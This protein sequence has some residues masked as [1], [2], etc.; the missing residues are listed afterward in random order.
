[1]LSRPAET[2]RRRGRRRRGGWRPPSSLRTSG[3]RS[4][5]CALHPSRGPGSLP[6]GGFRGGPAAIERTVVLREGRRRGSRS[7]RGPRGRGDAVPGGF[8]AGGAR[9]GAPPGGDGTRRMAGAAPAFPP[10]PS[11]GGRHRDGRGHGDPA[12]VEEAVPEGTESLDGA[13]ADRVRQYL[14]DRRSGAAAAREQLLAGRPAGRGG[15]RPF[16]PRGSTS[17]SSPRRAPAEIPPG[18]RSSGRRC[19]RSRF[20]EGV[21]SLF[22]VT[23]RERPGADA[24]QRRG[25]I[26]E[27]ISAPRREGGV[28][29]AGAGDR[30]GQGKGPHGS[31]AATDRGKTMTRTVA[32]H[33]GGGGGAAAFAGRRSPRD[34]RRR[35][36]GE[37]GADHLFRGAPSRCR[38]GWGSPWATRTRS[39]ANSAIPARCSAGRALVDSVLV[40]QGTGEAGP[41]DRG[42]GRSTGRR[43]RP[44]GDAMSEA[45]SPTFSEEGISRPRTA[46]LRWQMERGAIAG[47]GSSRRSR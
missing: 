32:T 20:R 43:I 24:G 41:A 47:R 34:R 18:V 16:R 27:A 7:P 5:R 28:P 15:R 9:E 36:A 31:A 30:G 33:R 40:R 1:M 45:Q 21:T 42:G 22:Q 37:R 44:E 25:R 19:Q 14:F 2:V 35:R 17:V 4:S 13:G 46:P 29:G 26:R 3:T 39:C 23:R 8:P 12:G 38:K 11:V 6:R 10:V